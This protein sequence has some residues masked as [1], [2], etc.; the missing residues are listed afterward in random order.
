MTSPYSSPLRKLLD[1]VD[2]AVAAGFADYEGESVQ[3]EGALD[4]DTHRLHLAYQGIVL[5]HLQSVHQLM[6][7]TPTRIS[8][9]YQNL[10]VIIQPLKSGYFIVL[11]L[12]PSSNL[13]RAG[14]CLEQTAQEFNQ[15]L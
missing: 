14:H 15:D 9:R 4:D 12:K 8:C 11:T 3:F 5:H 1:S 2:G 10:H 7:E 13:Y 6:G